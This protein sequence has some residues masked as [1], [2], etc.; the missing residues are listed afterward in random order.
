MVVVL[1]VAAGAA[2][3]SPVLELIGARAGMVVL[4]RC[5]DVD[6]LLA[7]SSAGQA[8]AAVVALD[9]PGLDPTAVD[10]LHRH[11]VRVVAVGPD[12]EKARLRAAR[13]GVDV[14][15]ADDDLDGLPDVLEAEVDSGSSVS[16]EFPST[17][18]ADAVSPADEDDQDDHGPSS[19]S[20]EAGRVCVVWGPAGSPGRTT[21]A[22]ALA[23]LLARRGRTTLV[24]CDPYG[25][26]VAQ[27]LGVLDEISGLLSAARLTAEG[28]LEARFDAVQ[29]RVGDRLTVVTGLPRGERW[30]EVRAG[31]AEHL[32]EIAALRGNVVV[33]TGF[34][35]EDDPA[36]D[37]TSRPGRNQLTLGALDVADEV[38]VVGSA[39]PVGLSRLARGLV[40]LRERQGAAPVRVVVNRMR[41][42]VGWTE[43]DVAGM[44]EGFAR[45]AGVHFLPDDQPA[46]DRALTTGASVVDA[47]DSELARAL[48]TLADALAPPPAPRR[49][50]ERRLLPRPASLVRTRRGGTTRRR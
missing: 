17:A 7:I 23:A 34:S 43:R 45:L 32:L 13:A 6:E 1:V 30:V 48:T 41:P 15:L 27:H 25:G 14:L 35:L 33:D 50:A 24:D 8:D 38:L 5:V 39:D 36:G 40:D 26:S 22:V 31:V 11:Q 37:L 20:G 42:S 19:E 16:R 12:S 2:W 9:A 47:G 3:E 29:R 10:V 44:V 46:A 18:A 4:K 28:A 49:R 21:V